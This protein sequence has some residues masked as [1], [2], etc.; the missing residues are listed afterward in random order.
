MGRVPERALLE[1]FLAGAEA[2][3]GGTEA[4]DLLVLA[5]E[6]GIGKT[7]L[8]EAALEHAAG[9]GY[10]VLASR[11]TEA[12]ARL[13]FAGLVDL[14]EAIEAA[15]AD[16]IAA[17]PEPQRI[18]IEVA[19]RRRDPLTWTPEN[20]TFAMALLSLIRARGERPVLLAIDDL[21][22]LDPAS[23]DCLAHVVRRL[24]AGTRML[25]ARRA[26]PAGTLER[27]AAR[28]RV[29]RLDL[30]PLPD[31]DMR[32]L[33][34]RAEAPTGVVD[35]AVESAQGNPL[36][37]LELT[38]LLRTSGPLPAADVP[39]PD[40]AADVFAPRIAD[41]APPTRRLLLALALS[42]EMSRDELDAI[43]GAEEQAI[44]QDLGLLRSDT[45]RISPAHPLLGAAAR[46]AATPAE[47]RAAH[48]LLAS[49]MRDALIRLKHQALAREGVDEDL[50]ASLAAAAASAAASGAVTDA[51]TLAEDALRLTAP[52]GPHVADRTLQLA[53]L[54]LSAGEHGLA[55][56]QMQ[57][58]LEWL[59]SATDR[60]RAHLLL[61]EASPVPEDFA[62][63]AL[64]LAEDD[65]DQIRAVALS[66][67]ATL[68]IVGNAESPGPAAETA[69]IGLEAARRAGDAA[70]ERRA[71]AVLAWA[72]VFLGRPVDVPECGSPELGNH[73]E[74]PERPAAVRLAA[75]GHLAEAEES[76]TR[77][78]GLA[79]D[80]GQS[81]SMLIFAAHL[82]ELAIRRGDI[83]GA[84]GWLRE[85]P[86]LR[87]SVEPS[88]IRRR[89]LGD[90]AANSGDAETAVRL[91]SA[92]LTD[93]DNQG[94]DAVAARRIIGLGHLRAG[95]YDDAADQLLAVWE[96][97][98]RE[99]I[100]EPGL[101][102]IAGD[103]VD[104]L[105]QRGRTDEAVAVIE[106]LDALALAQDHPWAT[107][108]VD[109][110][111]A[112]I[113]LAAEYQQDHVDRLE[114]CAAQYRELGLDF[115]AARTL[116]GCG[117]RQRRADRRAA[118][119]T[120]LNDAA[121]LFSVLGCTGWA[122]AATEEAAAISG[123]RNHDGDLTPSQQRVAELA[124]AGH[125]N[126][127]IA[128]ELFLSV[129]TV[130]A[131]LSRAYAK[132]GIRSRAQLVHHLGGPSQ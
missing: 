9:R 61:A 11:A 87:G 43:A 66:R 4:A 10:L 117:Q 106:R 104:A 82:F 122:E 109:R 62:H 17:L 112:L 15:D 116:L 14:V 68:N 89:F 95:R 130:E 98:A 125:S 24:P 64:A 132:L 79:T 32:T 5:G 105:T 2:T 92:T 101:F 55:I 85:F 49:C 26:G 3:P 73:D 7:S 121:G 77:L 65:S 74:F 22:W 67:R 120:T 19:L 99:G 90:I 50:S 16:A 63:I 129:H 103:L 83:P 48:L 118:A 51:L 84:R 76:F 59:P 124:A 93:P 42:G 100:D 13:P 75:R 37:A 60:A 123:R 39:L 127:Q 78:R 44:A 52:D 58:A 35:R 36:F 30:D 47:R 107:I 114:K 1:A 69:R 45:R 21:Q 28:D 70:S 94:W 38:R 40:S 53:R 25:V 113:A 102:P 110:C 12:D 91:G 54:R 126:R 115:D 131:H 108:T 71:I 86:E 119:R 18:A 20:L 34:A 29:R 88:R 81:I 57:D 80:S 41:L 111:R 97:C 8:W 46:E 27:A 72:D 56:T 6:P 96:H 31:E 33:L 128:Q 23:A